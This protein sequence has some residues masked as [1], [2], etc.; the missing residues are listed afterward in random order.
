MI[1][2][3]EKNGTKL[4]GNLFA[5]SRQDALSNEVEIEVEGIIAMKGVINFTPQGEMFF[6]SI[7]RYELWKVLSIIPDGM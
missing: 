5:S 1:I 2:F 7:A 4:E 3:L 6:T